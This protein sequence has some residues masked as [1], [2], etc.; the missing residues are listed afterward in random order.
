V[1]TTNGALLWSFPTDTVSIPWDIASTFT[2]RTKI[3]KFLA[4]ASIECMQSMLPKASKAGV[5][6]P[7]ARNPANPKLIAQMFMNVLVAYG[8]R[9][10]RILLLL[11]AYETMSYGKVL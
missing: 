2:F 10:P 8:V 3:S 4:D 6:Q 1:I 9:K 5:A 11:S 7:E